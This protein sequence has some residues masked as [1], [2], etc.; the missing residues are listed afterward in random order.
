MSL[1]NR[2][3]ILKFSRPVSGKGLKETAVNSFSQGNARNLHRIIKRATSS[4]GSRP[5]QRKRL[6]ISGYGKVSSTTRWKSMS[7]LQRGQ[8]TAILLSDRNTLE[9]GR[10]KHEMEV[11]YSPA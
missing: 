2:L 4:Q 9:T 7:S 5:R 1:H 3:L 6:P 8:F 10:L 11:K